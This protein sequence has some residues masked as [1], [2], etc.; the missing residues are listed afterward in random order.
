[1]IRHCVLIRFQDTVSASERTAIFEA[2]AAL[3]TRVPG[4][5]AVQAGRNN[6][7]E[8]L[9]KGFSD[10]FVV[11]FEDAGARDR[12]LADSEHAKVGARIVAAAQDGLAG[13]L[14]FD[15]EIAN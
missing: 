14:V 6:S 3:Q 12:Y 15:L 10:G 4:F 8:G 9:D 5:L 7:P 1:M 11:D 2:V 13:V